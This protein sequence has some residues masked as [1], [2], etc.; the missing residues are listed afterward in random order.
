MLVASG[1]M[2]VKKV[3]NTIESIRLSRHEV[4]WK[5]LEQIPHSRLGLLAKVH[6]LQHFCEKYLFIWYY[7]S[8][9][10]RP[11]LAIF[12]IS[13]LH[14]PRQRLM[15][16]YCNMRASTTLWTMNISLIG[17]ILSDHMLLISNI[18]IPPKMTNCEVMN[19]HPRSF[20]TILNFYRT[21]KL[22]V[23]DEMCALAFKLVLM[24]LTR[25]YTD[26][27]RF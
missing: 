8:T 21:G 10:P 16:K 9:R 15:L 6:I 22:H 2:V 1:R 25:I 3:K 12:D 14:I 23:A 20:N 13:R 19:R 4:L 5:I 18:I 27:C 24:I 7:C 11:N 17:T 26:T